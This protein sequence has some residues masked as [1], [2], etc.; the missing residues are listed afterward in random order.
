M[1]HPYLIIYPPSISTQSN[2]IIEEKSNLTEST[3]HNVSTE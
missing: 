1:I 2:I 3:I